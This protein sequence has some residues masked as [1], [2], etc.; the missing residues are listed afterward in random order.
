MVLN[1]YLDDKENFRRS[2]PSQKT[3]KGHIFSWSNAQ[4]L[5]MLS[6]PSEKLTNC[7]MLV[8]ISESFYLKMG[9]LQ[10]RCPQ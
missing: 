1:R 7:L 4:K 9:F 3:E 5:Y 6:P 10:K 8:I 2:E